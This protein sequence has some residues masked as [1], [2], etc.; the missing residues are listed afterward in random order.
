M[1]G[2]SIEEI[3]LMGGRATPGVVRVG[4]TV[5]RPVKADAEYTDA[6]LLHLERCGFEGAPSLPRG[7][8]PR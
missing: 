3:P 1:D 8:R 5:R 6:L 2:G 4:N 7:R